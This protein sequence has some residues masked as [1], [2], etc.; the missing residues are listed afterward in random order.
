MFGKIFKQIY[1]SS[2]AEDLFLRIVF[3]DFIILAD[4]DGVVDMTPEAISRRTNVPLDTLKQCITRLES[5]DPKSRSKDFDGA[6]IIRLDE[7]RDWGWKVVNYYRY[8]GIRNEDERKAYKR[9]WIAEKR[10]KEKDQKSELVDK[11]RH[12]GDPSPSSSPSS[13]GQDGGVGEG[14]SEVPTL[15]QAITQCMTMC[16][17][18][19]FIRLVYSKWYEREGRD[20]AGN[21]VPWMRHVKGRW[22]R[23]QGS[24]KNGTHTALKNSGNGAAKSSDMPSWKAI[25]VLEEA[26]SKHPANS[27]STFYSPQAT[28]QQR[29]N[30]KKLRERLKELK[31]SEVNKLCG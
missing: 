9:S 27:Q 19:D 24:W 2:I 12:K 26:V 21:L 8:R 13:L 14:A 5:P 4:I 16:I 29:E 6:R 10:L 31:A 11:S 23:E 3:Q 22:E 30:L 25:Q 20:G 15:D 7:H 18:E 17:P 1:D 28:Q